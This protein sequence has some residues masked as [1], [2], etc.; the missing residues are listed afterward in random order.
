MGPTTQYA[1]RSARPW[2]TMAAFCCM[3]PASTSILGGNL[4]S[5]LKKFLQKLIHPKP[6]CFSGLLIGGGVCTH[7]PRPYQTPNEFTAILSELTSV[8]LASPIESTASSPRTIPSANGSDSA[9]RSD[10][11]APSRP[12]SISS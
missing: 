11:R 5:T 8:V 10:A 3:P 6:L 2:A 4:G 12:P 1:P 7:P 9:G